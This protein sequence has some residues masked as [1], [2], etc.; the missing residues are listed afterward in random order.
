M[1]T[2][3]KISEED[4]ETLERLQAFVTVRACRKMT[5]Q[6][7]LSALVRDAYANSDE[8]LDKV[9]GTGESMSDEKYD[10]ILLL[11]EDWGVETSWT[12]LDQL[13]YGATKQKK[14]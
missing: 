5:Q 7:I 2:S 6:E 10:K 3:I 1:S 11:I 12:E 14:R 8:F 9:I 13:L 4:K